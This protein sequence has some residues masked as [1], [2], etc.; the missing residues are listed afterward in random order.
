MSILAF[1]TLEVNNAEKPQN[2]TVRKT[3]LKKEGYSDL[4]LMWQSNTGK[5]T[6]VTKGSDL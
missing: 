4:S 2:R 6:Q 3:L 5:P 1:Q